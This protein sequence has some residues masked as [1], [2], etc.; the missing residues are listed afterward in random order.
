MARIAAFTMVYNET[1]FLP[2]WLNHYGSHF[3]PENLFVIDDGSSDA[4]TRLPGIANLLSKGR[5]ALDEDD[6]AALV[7]FMH[8]ELL[9]FYDTVI[10]TDADEFIVIDPDNPKSLAS[11]LVSDRHP[12][13]A[14]MGLEIVQRTSSEGG[15]DFNRPLFAQ[16]RFARFDMAYTKPLIATVPIRWRAGFHYC[17]VRYAIDCNLILLHFRS[18]DRE[19]S[20]R[21][22]SALNAIRLTDNSLR[23]DH[24]HQFR[25]DE[26]SYLDLLYGSDDADFASACL[27]EPH[28]MFQAAKS[29]ASGILSR[30]NLDWGS[31]V[32]LRLCASPMLDR[33][34]RPLIEREHLERSF[35]D[36]MAKMVAIRPR[37]RNDV[38]PCGSGRRYKHCHGA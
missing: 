38:C 17:N 24:A 3:G 1:I 12:C 5:S 18:V 34:M 14:P 23:Q 26:T 16:R 19:L 15:I 27:Q 8:E 2:L 13:R 9:K 32:D 21:R 33:N 7:S 6:R 20:R 29:R 10:Y 25:L 35:A 36:A 4:S 28:V 22:I 30:I 37:G 31:R 11:Y